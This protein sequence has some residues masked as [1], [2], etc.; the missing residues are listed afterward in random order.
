MELVEDGEKFRGTAKVLQ[1]F[2]VHQADCIKGLAGHVYESCIYSVL[3]ISP[4]SASA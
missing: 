2:P 1:D 3:C 4:V